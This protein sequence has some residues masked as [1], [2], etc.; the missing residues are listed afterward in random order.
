M[1]ISI[2]EIHVEPEDSLVSVERLS[3][4]DGQIRSH[5]VL[6][7]L[8]L[9]EFAAKCGVT[10][11]TTTPVYYKL[12]E[13]SVDEFTL[14][15]WTCTDHVTSYGIAYK[16][17]IAR[18]IPAPSNEKQAAYL[19]GHRTALKDELEEGHRNWIPPIPPNSIRQQVMEELLAN[20]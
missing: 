15:R 3:S 12:G 10:N 11:V 4:E 2:Q 14:L 6:P 13:V 16:G 1:M 17:M 19:T 20:L 9:S 18:I 5:P 8:R 7:T